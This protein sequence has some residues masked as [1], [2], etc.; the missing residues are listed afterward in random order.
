VI[1]WYTT[2]IRILLILLL[3]IN[4]SSAFG[5]SHNLS[6]FDEHFDFEG[7]VGYQFVWGS[8]RPEPIDST[9][10]IGFLINYTANDNWTWFTQ[11]R[12]ETDH[13]EQSL[14]YSFIQYDNV[15]ADTVPI[16]IIGGKLRH[17]YG[18]YNKDRLNPATRPGNIAPQSMYW[19]QIRYS[20]TSGWGISIGSNWGNLHFKYTI[21]IPIV[22]DESE[23]AFIW[24]S[25]RRNNLQQR[26]GGHQLINIDYYGDD[27][28]ISQATTFQDWGHGASGKNIIVS[29]GG[30]KRIGDW[31]LSLEGMGLFKYYNY[32]YALSATIQYDINDWLSVHTNYHHYDIISK[33]GGNAQYFRWA[34]RADDI[35]IGTSVHM[36]HWE[37]KTEAHM[38]TGSV[39]VDFT[40]SRNPDFENWWTYGAV[41]L[42]YHF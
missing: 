5:H 29:L 27:W 17:Q 23:E 18:L 8:P 25:G 42:T 22:V 1:I 11:F 14:S 32:S 2:M 4:I 20:L 41:S 7:Y 19:D 28:R 6:Y 33:K 16:T 9:P 38:A 15:I 37:L 12:L 34:Q 31:T 26:F 40:K 35:S 39:W 30:E 36:D 24:F 13:L 3:L 21:D 10:E